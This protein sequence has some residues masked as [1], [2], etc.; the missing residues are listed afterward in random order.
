MIELLH[1][2]LLIK[3]PTFAIIECAGVGYGVQISTRTGNALPESNTECTLLTHLIVREDSMT[4]FGFIDEG[5]KELFIKMIDVN[6]I[7]PKMAQRILSSVSP[8]DFLNMIAKEDKASLSKIKGVGKKTVEQL[9]LALKDK[10]GTIAFAETKS[11]SAIL[12]ASEQEA[13]LALQ[14]LGVKELAAKDAVKKASQILG[15]N[16]DIAV[17]ITEAL[18]YT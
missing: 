12:N 3:H 17:L 16:T 14:T 5:E 1:G 18:K 7:G 11:E 15:E 4:L 9:I 6:G 10:A 8:V 13:I 2:K